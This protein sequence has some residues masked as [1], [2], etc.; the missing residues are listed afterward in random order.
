MILHTSGYH[1]K[2]CVCDTVLREFTGYMG[3]EDGHS[4]KT[5]GFLEEEAESS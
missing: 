1:Y 5:Q 2:A 3:R 4:E